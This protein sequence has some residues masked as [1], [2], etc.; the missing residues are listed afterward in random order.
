MYDDV[1]VWHKQYGYK[2]AYRYLVPRDDDDD[3]LS[4]VRLKSLAGQ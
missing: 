3:G 4:I 1:P 2:L